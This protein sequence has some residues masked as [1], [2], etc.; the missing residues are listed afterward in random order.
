MRGHGTDANRPAASGPD[1]L[2]GGPGAGGSRASGSV[3][4]GG[5]VVQV[6]RACGSGRSGGRRQ[7]AGAGRAGG[8]DPVD[9]P[10]ARGVRGRRAGG[11][12]RVHRHLRRLQRH[13][14]APRPRRRGDDRRRRRDLRRRGHRRRTAGRRS[15][16]HVALS[17]G[18][19][20]R[21]GGRLLP[22]R[23]AARAGALGP[24]RR[25]LRDEDVL[26]SQH[27]GHVG[28]VRVDPGAGRARGGAGRAGTAVGAGADRNG[29]PARRRQRPQ[30]VALRGRDARDFGDL[31]RRRPAGRLSRR[32]RR[33]LRAAGPVQG[34]LRAAGAGRGARRAPAPVCKGSICK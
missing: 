32:G 25:G 15:A 13:L 11:R 12:R 1:G 27:Q 9:L 10:A 28:P 20:R 21:P 8:G 3:G 18:L 17:V 6:V 31:R 4:V 23:S 14:A 24:H 34:A 2:G 16:A 22:G 33:D 7:P 29:A 19:G 5:P 30:G 26:R